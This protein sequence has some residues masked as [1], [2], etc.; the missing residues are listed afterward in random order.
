M[1]ADATERR[2]RATSVLITGTD[3]TIA[4]GHMLASVRRGLMADCETSGG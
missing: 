4:A 2:E 3:V 1:F